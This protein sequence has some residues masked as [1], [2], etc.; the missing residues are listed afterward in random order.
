MS[1]PIDEG[2]AATAERALGALVAVARL[3]DERGPSS[4]ASCETPDAARE[5][6]AGA[7]TR[8]QRWASVH[9]LRQAEAAILL[10]ELAHLRHAVETSMRSRSRDVVVGLH[11]ALQRLRQAGSREDLASLVPREASALGFERVLFSWVEEQRWVPQSAFMVS[12]PEEARAVMEAGLPPY[13]HTRDLLERQMVRH[14]LPM[15]VTHALGH[16]QVH[17]DIQAVMQSRSYVAAPLV[18]D[19]QVIGFLHAD[20]N[21]DTGDVDAF[22]RDLVHMF[23][24][25]V[26]IALERVELMAEL[27]RLRER[28]RGQ[29]DAL[30]A[31]AADLGRGVD[32]SAG[33]EPRDATDD[34]PQTIATAAQVVDPSAD[35]RVGL[36][37]R[38]EQVSDLLAAGMSNSQIAARLY[39]TQET[40]KT[41]VRN[42][43]RKLGADN[44]AHAAALWRR[45]RDQG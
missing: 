43:L 28:A 27:S 16:P 14:H 26:M 39:I 6:L 34:R 9:Q 1:A 20:R 5:A 17:Q 2:F 36:T 37:R 4:A 7:E 45:V 44:R 33:S 10:G 19:G 41:H 38:E 8:L 40:A 25:G 32:A 29:A 30:L 23:A 22:D 12:G 11:D 31:L 35:R 3:L 15:L 13:W 21:A 24:E 18:R 42:V